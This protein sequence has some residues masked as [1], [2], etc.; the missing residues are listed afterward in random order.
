MKI[1][2]FVDFWAAILKKSNIWNTEADITSVFGYIFVYDL[3]LTPCQ[4]KR[5]HHEVKSHLT[6]PLRG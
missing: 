6:Y 3:K 4:R 1:T 2:T 5:L